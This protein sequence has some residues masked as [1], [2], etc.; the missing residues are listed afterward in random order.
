[1]LGGFFPIEPFR[2][3][4][5]LAFRDSFESGQ[6]LAS[7]HITHDMGTDCLARIGILDAF[8]GQVII[9]INEGKCRT[10]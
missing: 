3:F 10:V 8:R 1:M 7:S 5:V 2:T 9:V 4:S 6:A